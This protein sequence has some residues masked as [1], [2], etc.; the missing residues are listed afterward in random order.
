MSDTVFGFAMTTIEAVTLGL[1]LIGNILSIIIFS[2]KTF[3]NNSIS[4]YCIALALCELWNLLVFIIDI[5]TLTQNKFLYDQSDSLC[6]LTYGII[7][8]TASI[9]P[10]IMV[11][12]S[13]DKLLSMRVSS[14]AILKK[15]WF[16]WSVVAGIVLFT[17]ALYIYVPLFIRVRELFPG[18]S[19]CD[20]TSIGF[21]NTHIVIFTF[22]TCLIPFF[23][24]AFTSIL[25]ILLLIK[26]RNSVAKNGQVTRERKSRDKKFAITSI[27]F[28]ITFII[29][30]L[31]SAIFYI[32]L[33]YYSLYDSNFQRVAS[34]T[35]YL[36]MSMS[37]FIHLLTNS[38]FR[39]EFLVLLRLAKE[40]QVS[41]TNTNSTNL[42][43]RRIKVSAMN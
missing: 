35:Y 7:T 41:V 27:T 32:L 6:K 22:E 13:L 3:R 37:F 42:T 24:M 12:F 18:Y 16:Q 14:I 28:N 26:S 39:R 33:A 38:I 17:A 1:G 8:Y 30:K 40:N 29:L 4:T 21:F 36:N 10:W 15:K 11:A 20:V 43:I 25:T 9:Q 2:R 23:F 5:Y 19:L 31:P 34:Y